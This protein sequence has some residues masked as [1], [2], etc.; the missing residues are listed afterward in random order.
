MY[1]FE[2]VETGGVGGTPFSMAWQESA[3]DS[4]PA[5]AVPKVGL[6]SAQDEPLVEKVMVE[7]IGRKW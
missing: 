6:V 7:T 5:P 4:P 3:A 1:I 2:K